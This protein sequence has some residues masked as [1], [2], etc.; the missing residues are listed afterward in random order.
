MVTSWFRGRW[1]SIYYARDS[2]IARRFRKL[3]LT[4]NLLNLKWLAEQSC[5]TAA[6]KSENGFLLLLKKV[7]LFV[8]SVMFLY[9]VEFVFVIVANARW[10]DKDDLQS[11]LDIM[12]SIEP[13]LNI[14]NFL[15][16]CSETGE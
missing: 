9:Y 11:E 2:P 7:Q 8:V 15:G 6:D 16:M 5:I 1:A 3:I 13:H 10:S 12:L 4:M 14:I